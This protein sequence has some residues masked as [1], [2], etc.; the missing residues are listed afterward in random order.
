MR[1][2][3]AWLKELLPAHEPPCVSIY[4]PMERAKPPATA[5]PRLF[6]DLVE[7]ACAE[8]ERAYPRKDARAMAD[9]I[10]S[11]HSDDRFW[12][13]PRDGLAVFASPDLLRAFDLQQ[14]GNPPIVSVAD[15]FHLKPLIRMLEVDQRYHVLALTMREVRVF[16]G[17]RDGLR[18]LDASH[19][20]QDPDVVSKMRLNRHVDVATDLATPDTQYPGEGSA[21]ASV[22]AARFM[23][24]VDRAVWEGF[25]R[26]AK[27]PL[28]LVADEKP[29]ALFR[30]LSRNIHLM[31]Q[32]SM[33]DP[34]AMDPGRLHRETWP[35]VEPRF[36]EEALRLADRFM[37]A[38][39]HQ[40]GTAE[41][42]PAADAAAVGRVDTLLVDAAR[43][44]PGRLE[45]LG[46]NVEFTPAD[47]NDP[48]ATDALDDLAEIVLKADGS[49]L[50][51]PTDWM[52][53]TTG[54]A[55]IYRY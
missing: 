21:P 3:N 12:V 37:A 54:L 49:V 38:K 32:G 36:R 2:S 23:Q 4:M 25:S 41:L 31:E 15:T 34:K 51:L 46:A 50:V 9:R 27:L 43:R 6:R 5:N 39:A 29:N 26:D 7:G 55:A 18:D 35:L 22:A 24:A 19:V 8:I 44:I 47:P 17:D 13:G 10:S 53:T 45:P 11:I 20:P 52:P 30:S 16:E 48:R 14:W 28:I 1:L 33:L 40:R 42:Q